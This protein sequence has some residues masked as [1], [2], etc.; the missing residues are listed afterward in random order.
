MSLSTRIC[1]LEARRRPRL[2]ELFPPSLSLAEIAAAWELS[3]DETRADLLEIQA[4]LDRARRL[5][6]L[7]RGVYH[8]ALLVTAACYALNAGVSPTLYSMV[9]AWKGCLE[10]QGI[11]VAPGGNFGR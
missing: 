3:E 11:T 2:C 5:F 6:G 10:A 8:E 7:R 4:A 1:R 9:D